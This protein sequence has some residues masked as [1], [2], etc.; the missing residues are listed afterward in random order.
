M[1][2]E[3]SNYSLPQQPIITGPYSPISID[4][5]ALRVAMRETESFLEDLAQKRLVT[6]EMER[7][8]VT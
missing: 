2:N 8:V 3:N 7:I 4:E 6:D 5:N 1:V